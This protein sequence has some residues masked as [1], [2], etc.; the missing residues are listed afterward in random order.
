AARRLC[1]HRPN[2]AATHVAAAHR[3]A[4]ERVEVVLA[5]LRAFAYSGWREAS[6]YGSQRRYK[7]RSAV[8]PTKAHHITVS[9]L[10][11]GPPGRRLS[12]LQS[13]RRAR[14][15]TRTGKAKWPKNRTAAIANPPPKI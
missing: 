14:P 13:S 11:T 8:S 4:Q 7:F 1:S 5:S 6:D 3:A 10:L 2:R 15:N 9:T 12:G